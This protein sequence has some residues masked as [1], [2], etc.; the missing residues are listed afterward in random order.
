MKKAICIASATALLFTGSAAVIGAELEYQTAVAGAY[1][2]TSDMIFGIDDSSIS[3]DWIVD[4]IYTYDGITDNEELSRLASACT[5]TYTID[6][7]EETPVIFG[8]YRVFI[9]GNAGDAFGGITVYGS[10]DDISYTELGGSAELEGGTW[11]DIALQTSAAYRYI[12]V[13]TEDEE[14]VYTESSDT[15]ETTV[16]STDDD[17]GESEVSEATQEPEAEGYTAARTVKAVFIEASPAE[18]GE[19]T[20][21]TQIGGGVGASGALGFFGSKFPDCRGHW[22][23]EIIVQCTDRNLL[24]GYDDGNFYPDNPVT[25]AEFAKLYSAWQSKFY[26]VNDGY[27]AMPYIRDL[28]DKGIFEKNDYSD[29]SAYMTREM[30]AKAVINSLTG[31]YFP[32]DLGQFREYITDIDEADSACADYVLKAYISGIM[33]GYD[34]GSFDPKGYVTRAEILTI[35]NRAMNEDQRDI[36]EIAAA[37]TGAAETQTYYTAAVQ[38]RKSTSA[39]SMNFR[40]YGANSKY[41]TE[42]DPGSG[43][44]VYDEFQGAQG[45]AFLMRYDLSDIIE[46]EDSLTSIK[47]II[48]RH[49]NGDIPIGLFWYEYKLSTLDWNQS[50]YSQVVNNSAVAGEDKSLY[51]S[52]VDNISAILPTWGNIEGAVPQEEKVQPF[53]Q[54]ELKDNQYV[55]ELSLDELKA[56]MNEDNI[57][58]FFATTVN[59]DRY[60][61][62]KDNKPRCYTA[63]EL[64]PQL[65]CTFDTGEGGSSRIELNPDEAEL[66]GGMLNVEETDGIKN[67][68]NFTKDQKITYRF[69]ASGAGTYKMTINY[70]ANQGS[71]GGTARIIMNGSETE[72]SFAETGSWTTYVY[73]DVGTYEL[74]AGENTLEI[75]DKAITSTYLINIREIILEKVN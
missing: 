67:L 45:M 8:T 37:A 18:D 21:S 50:G 3:A 7:G 1:H 6:L 12:K 24:D 25:A 72:H 41:M 11:N 29:Y 40:L 68:G 36:P 34:D 75:A 53:V 71:G 23:E 51:N 61:M 73:E 64:A 13:E 22:A 65:Y 20:S 31:E 47:L 69:N 17:S 35:I 32:S 74:K 49:S 55:F 59:Y 33:S 9:T 28:L 48:N 42:D 57:V 54:A 30:C 38:V 27:W 5:A 46:R 19:N 2:I 16:G 70:A 15:A 60:G 58:E 26:I 62:E 56:H 43:L 39:N 14:I 63:G 52:V 66:F 10:N 4:N 44:K